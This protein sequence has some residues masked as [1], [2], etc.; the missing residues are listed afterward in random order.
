MANRFVASAQTVLTKWHKSGTQYEY[1]RISPLQ[2]KKKKGIHMKKKYQLLVALAVGLLAGP[3]VAHAQYD[4]QLVD[5]PGAADT[6]VFGINDR[7]DVVGTGVAT[8]TSLPFVYDSKKGTYTDVAP[9]DG[10]DDTSIIGIDDAGNMVGSVFDALLFTETG[11]IRDKNGNFTVFSHPDA[12]SRTNPRAINN[13]GLVS[14]FRD[15]PD[16]NFGTTLVGFIYDPKNDAF[17]DLIPTATQT[18]AHGINS[19][20]DVVGNSFFVNAVDPCTGSPEDFVQY[21]WLRSAD[22]TVTYFN[23]NGLP[24]RARGINDSGTIAGFIFGSGPGK[25]FVIELDGSQCQEITVAASDLL[26]FPG[27][28]TLPEGITNSG[29]VA[30]IADD[31]INLHG[32]IATPQ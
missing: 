10:F 28:E 18:I 5:H 31:G 29:D 19:R 8:P 7:G 22:G 6:Q 27:F 26:E 4:Y 9:L 14:G 20:G 17:T 15:R 12:F 2:K 23:V 30:G 3:M 13:M 21:S 1:G 25:G 16:P 24:T 11:F 32:F